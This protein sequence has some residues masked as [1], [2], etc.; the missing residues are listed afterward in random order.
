[1]HHVRYASCVALFVALIGGSVL[2][3]GFENTGVGTRGRAM[4]G[5]FR[6]IADDW[7][8]AYYNPAGL[9]FIEENTLS[10]ALG[11]FQSRHEL[12]PNYALSDQFGNEVGWGIPNDQTIYNFH[13]TLTNPSGG[14]VVRLP[15]WGETVF[16]LSAYQPFDYSIGW[17]FYAPAASGFQAYN[18]EAEVLAPRDHYV[19]DLDVVAFQLSAG[20][21]F[22]EDEL[23]IGLGLQVLRGDLVFGNLTFR[24]NPMT[25]ELADRPRDRIPEF[26]MNDGMGWGFGIKVGAIWK[27]AEKVNLAITGNVPFDI[28]LDGTTRFQFIM[29]EVFNPG[30]L[31]PV[32][33]RFASGGRVET[34]SDVKTKLQL[35]ASFALGVA[36]DV[37]DRLT[38]TADA[39]YTLWSKFK[40]FEFTYSNF[41][42]LPQTALDGFLA[43]EF[44]SAN[45]TNPLEW[46]DAGKIMVGARYIANDILTLMAG[47]SDDQSPARST[48]DVLPQFFDT[49]DKMSFNGGFEVRIDRWDLG[50]MT[51]YYKYPEL[52][53]GTLT[54]QDGDG[55]FDNF[56]GLYDGE[57]YETVVSFSYRF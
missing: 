44:F 29:P 8:A 30:S 16:G 53:V 46:D 41:E 7:S 5:A 40:G 33:L 57:F 23:S 32:E 11:T 17:R 6:A 51:S 47:F 22:I 25:G 43:P 38:L 27:P 56:P 28:T 12:S 21:E 35:P 39:E 20:R 52:T 48:N 45:L 24:D 31:D 54:D 36:F 37:T 13:R 42:G 55:N 26:T 4:G 49:G 34:F 50:L 19:N 3:S 18:Q 2:A 10:G 1:M 14:V 9:A 15:F